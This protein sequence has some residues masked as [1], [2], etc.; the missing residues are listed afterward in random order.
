MSQDLVTPSILQYQA[1]HITHA[2]HLWVVLVAIPE[3]MKLELE[4]D[5]GQGMRYEAVGGSSGRRGWGG[6]VGAV[7][8]A[9]T[10]GGFLGSS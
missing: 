8:T 3:E 9:L 10:R 2:S 6:W 1:G 7:W 5:W 4:S